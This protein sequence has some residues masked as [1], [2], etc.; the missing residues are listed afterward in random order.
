MSFKNVGLFAV[1]HGQ[2]VVVGVRYSGHGQP[3]QDQ[4]AQW[5]MANATSDDSSLETTGVRKTKIVARLGDPNEIPAGQTSISYLATI[6]NH[7]KNEVFSLEGG[8]TT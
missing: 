1:L 7:G 3:G 5:I 8:G 2:S 4:G 6:F